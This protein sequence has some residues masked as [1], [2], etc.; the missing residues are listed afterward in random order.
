M[1]KNTQ[2]ICVVENCNKPRLTEKRTGH[3]DALMCGMHKMREFKRREPLYTTYAGMRDRCNSPSHT[4]YAS[5][6]GRGIKVCSRW[7]KNFQQFKKDMGEKPTPKHSIDRIDNDSGYS[8][9]NCRW[10]TPLEQHMNMRLFSKN[11]SG[12]QGVGKSPKSA[13]KPW[14]AYVY[15]SRKQIHL[16]YF[17]TKEEAIYARKQGSIKHYGMESLH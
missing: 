2:T 16:G 12:I 5:Y 6:G 14:R 7:D 9:E 17:N 4:R 3:A 1:K 10:A 11:T 8:P 13:V 15:A